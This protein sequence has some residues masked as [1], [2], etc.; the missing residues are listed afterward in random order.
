MAHLCLARS[1]MTSEQKNS[2]SGHRQTQGP[3]HGRRCVENGRNRSPQT[4]D[5][6]QQCQLW[7]HYILE[8]IADAFNTSKAFRLERQKLQYQLSGFRRKR[9]GDLK[10]RLIVIVNHTFTRMMNV[11]FFLWEIYELCNFQ[12]SI[13]WDQRW[14]RLV[15]SPTHEKTH[16]WN[17][18][19]YFKALVHVVSGSEK[20]FLD[21]IVSNQYI[22]P[23]TLPLQL[24]LC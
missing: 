6:L 14:T 17:S 7:L 10:R 2:S 8:S 18:S 5:Y 9:T 23:A 12:Q 15:P 13:C 22:W 19:V 11:T 24:D 20:V 4:C 3:V 1:I 21:N 16:W